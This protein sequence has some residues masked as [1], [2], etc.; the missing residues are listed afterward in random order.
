MKRA[1]LNGES[2][3]TFRR[4]GRD[5]LFAVPVGLLAGFASALFLWSLDRVTE[6]RWQQ[7]WLLWLLP[8]A[9]F[10]VGWVYHRIGQGAE[11][12][13]DLIL[14][15]IH[16]PGG[17]VPARMAPLVLVGTLATHLCG[18]SAGREG[19]A[20]QMGG[21]LADAFSRLC[22]LDASTR[23]ALLI[24]G[25]AAGFGSVFG[26]PLAG[27]LFALEVLVTG[28]LAYRHLLSALIASI[29]GDL[30]CTAWG[31]QHAVYTIGTSGSSFFAAPVEPWLLF[32][33]LAAAAV[34]G[35]V[36]RG[37]S[38]ITHQAHALLKRF[39]AYAPLRPLLGGLVVI[40]L[41]YLV[42]T[43]DYL[44]I[45]V[46][47]PDPR[48]VTLHSAFQTDGAGTWSWAWKL[49]FTVVTL[50]SGFK[51]GEVTPLFFIGATLGHTLALLLG[52]PAGLFAGL[53]LIA[54]FAG[55]TKTPLACTVLGIELFGAHHAVYF[56]LA[57]CVA[58]LV[59]GRTGIYS[60]QRHPSPATILASKAHKKTS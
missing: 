45:G 30:T 42:D 44:G 37:F 54:I 5:V 39:V 8:V 25:I 56:A 41:V 32:K 29:V 12:G 18:G 50:A 43:R 53:G 36:G 21:S 2:P 34:F 48:A 1:H 6:A 51:G 58:F 19:T 16:T 52:A 22:R 26:T 60:A 14:D 23:R 28:R 10:A 47:S 17:G 27:A 3:A 57:C 4:L 9:G 33:V 49:V 31:G 7:P 38:E 46:S 11:R 24:A 59:S 20:V 55:A 40:A 35:L 13:T 15:Q